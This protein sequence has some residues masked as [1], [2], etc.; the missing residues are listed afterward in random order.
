MTSPNS[1][2]SFHSNNKF[3]PTATLA[4][5]VQRVRRLHLRVDK[6][7][8]Q[9]RSA[10]HEHAAASSFGSAR[11]WGRKARKHKLYV[12][13]N[14]SITNLSSMPKFLRLWLVFAP[15]SRDSERVQCSRPRAD[16]VYLSNDNFLLINEIIL[17]AEDTLNS[18]RDG[19]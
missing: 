7:C 18:E 16:S 17:S 2:N 6:K 11:L 15:C 19:F 13:F 3:A 1:D 9:L 4:D 5:V 8:F 12:A 10:L 14:V